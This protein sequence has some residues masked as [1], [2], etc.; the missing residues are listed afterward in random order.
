[1]ET[2]LATESAAAVNDRSPLQ[3]QEFL[4]VGATGCE[5]LTPAVSRQIKVTA[6]IRRKLTN[7]ADEPSD[8]FILGERPSPCQYC[9]R[10]TVRHWLWLTVGQAVLDVTPDSLDQL[11]FHVLEY[12][13]CVTA[14]SLEEDVLLTQRLFGDST[15]GNGS[16]ILEPV[17]R[18]R[19][20][21]GAHDM[22]GAP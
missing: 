2:R 5:P 20:V 1:V 6:L 18:R 12:V 16:D 3:P 4:Y 13:R 7:S 21:Y 9:L 10:I 11:R 15:A 8:W 14:S 19:Q 22:S 17:Q